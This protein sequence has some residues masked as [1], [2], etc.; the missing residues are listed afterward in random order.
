MQRMVEPSRCAAGGPNAPN[1]KHQPWAIIRS[2]L[3]DFSLA[4]CARRIR[5][6]RIRGPAPALFWS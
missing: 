2:S 5:T 1:M 3:R 4:R 6:F